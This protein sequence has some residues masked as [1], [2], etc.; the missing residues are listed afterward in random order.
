[1]SE[2]LKTQGFQHK[3]VQ[4]MRSEPYEYI[5]SVAMQLLAYKPALNPPVAALYSSPAPILAQPPPQKILP[6]TGRH[7]PGCNRRPQLNSTQLD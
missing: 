2:Y 1:M 4:R 7:D 3:S 6:K 5:V